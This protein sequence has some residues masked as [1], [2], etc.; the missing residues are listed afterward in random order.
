MFLTKKQFEL[1]LASLMEE[2]AE[3]KKKPYSEPR[4]V[5]GTEDLTLTKD[6]YALLSQLGK[7]KVLASILDKLILGIRVTVLDDVDTQEDPQVV[8]EKI[9]ERRGMVRSLMKLQTLLKES[10]EE[11]EQIDYRTGQ[12]SKKK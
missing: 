7:Q 2:L 6:E 10:A 12:P 9:Y 3:Q 4:R 5:S 11:K 1:G 8:A